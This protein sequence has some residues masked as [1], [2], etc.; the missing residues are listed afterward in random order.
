MTELIDLDFSVEED[1]LIQGLLDAK[2]KN[3]EVL[4]FGIVYA[5]NLE[6]VDIENGTITIVDGEDKAMIEIERVESFSIV[7]P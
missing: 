6:D 3:V 5:G 7:V 1:A 4:A 2:G